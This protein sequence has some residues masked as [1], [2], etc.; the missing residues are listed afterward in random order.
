MGRINRRQVLVMSAA[1]LALA[2]C[3]TGPLRDNPVIFRPG[4]AMPRE[5]TIFGPTVSQ[6]NPLY[7]PQ[8]PQPEVYD[9]VFQKV[10]DTVDDFWEIAY[11]NRYEGRI[12]TQ[13]GVA[14]GIIQPW[15]PGSPDFRQRLLADLQSIRHR[16][17]VLI[18]TADEG[19]YYIDVKVLKELEDMPAPVRATAGSASFRMNSTIERQFEVIEQPLY[20]VNWIPIGRDFKLEQVILER[21]A[22][23]DFR[24]L[25][26][27]KPI[28]GPAPASEVPP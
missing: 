6:E 10:L 20:E 1:A 24:T 2:G 16:C 9:K 12:E 28:T 25:P 27:P 5:S 11:S 15:K 23:C 22:Q 8:G 13:P 7:L 21:L 26:N 4:Q 14:P 3:S 18:S 19:G 17:I